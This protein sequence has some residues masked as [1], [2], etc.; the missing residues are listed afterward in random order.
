M[1]FY[2][3]RQKCRAFASFFVILLFLPYVVSVFAG[4]AGDEDSPLFVRVG[5]KEADW[6]DFLAGILALELPEGSGDE[7]AKAMAVVLRTQFCRQA[8]AGEYPL[9]ETDF[10]T[11]QDMREKW[12]VSDGTAYYEKYAEAVEETAGSVLMYND[13]YAWTPY[14]QSSAG[15]TRSAQ[16]AAGSSDF[17]YLGVRECPLDK[18]AEGEISVHTFSCAEIQRLCRDFLAA[19]ESGEAAERGYSAADFEILSKDSAGYVQELRI[20]NTICTGDQFRDAL[21]LP[22]SSFVITELPEEEEQA[23][24]SGSS[25]DIR[26]TTTGKGHGLG[27]S[28]WTAVKMAEEGQTYDGILSFF[29]E[30]TELRKDIREADVFQDQNS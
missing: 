28:I 30:G 2:A 19:E 24:A 17:P 1:G 27:M 11:L 3:L 7:A 25:R 12:G 29:F 15:L 18:E 14:H 5:E 6:T 4:G 20:G 10:M 13:A 26:I 21:G 22:S 8:A 9:P 23:E 16:E